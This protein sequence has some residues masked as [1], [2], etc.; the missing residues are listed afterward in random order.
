MAPPASS[1]AAYLTRYLD[2]LDRRLD[3]LREQSRQYSRVRLALVLGTAVLAFTLGQVTSSAVGWGTALAGAIVFFI[4]ARFHT[5][6][7]DG[8]TRLRRWRRIKATHLA[9]IHLDWAHLPAPLET[10]PASPHPF[11]A[12][13]NLIG[14][15]SLHHL[16]DTTASRGG[17]ARLQSWLTAPVP[18]L[19]QARQRQRLVQALVGNARFRDK[20]ALYGA[21]MADSVHAARWDDASLQRWLSRPAPT[22]SLKPWLLGLSALAATNIVL[23]LLH[24]LGVLPAVWSVTLVAYVGLYLSRANSF[25]HLFDEVLDLEA[26]LRRISPVLR[27]LETTGWPRH[28]GLVDHCTPLQEDEAQP[29]AHLKQVQRIAAAVAITRNELLAVLL[30]VLLPW[31]LLFTHRFHTETDR[32]QEHLPRWLDAWYDLE[33]LSALARFADHHEGT[34]F[35]DLLDAGTEPDFDGRG[36]G[37]PLLAPDAKVRNDYRL[38]R[39]GAI[40]LITGSNMSGKSTFLRTVG[41]NL[42][43]AFAGGPVDAAALRTVPF[44][45]FTSLNVQDSVQDGLSFFYA[46]VRRLKAL[47]DALRADHPVPL[48]FLIDEIFRGTNNRERRIGSEAYVRALAEA[49]GTGLITT[50]DLELTALAEEIPTLRN[51]HFRE[52]VQEER[53]VFDYRL[54]PGPCPTTN[55]LKIMQLEGLPVDQPR[56]A[57]VEPSP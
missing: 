54:R 44:R 15:R 20:L 38:D 14:A 6:L 53:M 34:S 46:E 37:H 30:N 8:I 50:H 24:L 47:L 12:D 18:A 22:G 36:L 27:F 23:A 40:T 32:L 13:L 39:R 5:R 2:R 43:L 7:E 16:L 4:V 49:T 42:R 28:P 9:R 52:D 45:L 10:A 57:S 11:A 26:D 48:F 33:A 35:P 3:V 55:A 29:S 31:N 51:A 19:D 21:L 41:L 25:K 1:T 56:A 17:S